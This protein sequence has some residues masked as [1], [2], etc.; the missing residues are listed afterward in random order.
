[1]PEYKEVRKSKIDSEKVNILIVTATDVETKAL[2]SVMNNSIQKVIQGHNT[3]YIGFL[4]RYLICNVECLSMGSLN[5]GS[6]TIT[7][8]NALNEWKGIKAVMMV[9]ICFGIDD[10]KQKIGDIIIS[11]EIR[12]YETR[13]IGKDKEISRGETHISDMCLYNAFRNLN[14][15]W[16]YIGLDNQNKD[17]KFGSY[18]SGELLVDNKEVR[19]N[20][21]KENPEAQAGEMEGNGLVS[22]CVSARVAW[23]MLK[24]ICDFA[25]GNKGIDKI[26][27]Q[28]IAAYASANCCS[29]VLEQET[30]FEELGIYP[31]NISNNTQKQNFG[32]SKINVDDV[33]FEIYKK[34]SEPYYYKREIDNIVEAYIKSHNLWIYGNSGTGKSTTILYTLQHTN[35]NVILINLAG[36]QPESSLHQIFSWIY[37]EVASF[38]DVDTHAPESYQLCA[39]KIIS[40]LRENYQDETVYLL[41]EEIPFEGNAFKTFV[42]SLSS[43][44]I[45]DK[46]KNEFSKIHFIISSIENP[47]PYIPKHLQKIKSIMKFLQFKRWTNEECIGLIE[48]IKFYINVPTIK[49]ISEFI[50][51]C[52]NSPRTIKSIFRELYQTNFSDILDTSKIKELIEKQ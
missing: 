8:T 52:E 32:G 1:M 3:Y 13:R 21:L 51:L 26:Q 19:N 37:T 49:D 2:H 28:K 35:K 34:I 33:L 7:I 9:G 42:S 15:T 14:M 5:A 44:V 11:K 22:A 20:L 23:I 12:N 25:D 45:S 47:I 29:A 40:L 50:H 27:R 18:L 10:S 39:N 30:A 16:E 24:A 46:L 31:N 48:L 6:S 36:I 43:L 38:L 41:I 17:M 4:G